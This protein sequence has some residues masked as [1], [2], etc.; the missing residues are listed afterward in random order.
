[1]EETRKR[2][3][4]FRKGIIERVKR[5]YHLHVF[6][7]LVASTVIVSVLSFTTKSKT[8]RANTTPTMLVNAAPGWK[9]T[10]D[11]IAADYAMHNQYVMGHGVDSLAIAKNLPAP[12]PS[13]I[14]GW[15]GVNAYD[16]H[17]AYMLPTML[18]YRGAIAKAA[19]EYGIN[20]V[21]LAAV[22]DQ[23]TRL[24]NELD[25]NARGDHGHGYGIF[26]LDDQKRTATAIGRDIQVLETV[27]KD[28]L[29]AARY[30]ASML[31]A[32]LDRN[33]GSIESALQEYNAGK[34]TSHGAARKWPDAKLYYS[35]STL[36][37]YKY[38]VQGFA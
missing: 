20:P 12:F 31:R 33:V 13:V 9:T 14:G 37:Y 23:E 6:S 26:Q 7:S 15:D 17:T 5:N 3:S 38:L 35:N 24:G 27:A 29:Y 16:V 36:R 25:A 19:V 4:I 2:G 32:R 18:P 11:S 8:V 1:M 34:N 21:L 28:A 30:A 22:G 10:G